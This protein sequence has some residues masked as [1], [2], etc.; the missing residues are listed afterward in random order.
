MNV[1][2]NLATGEREDIYQ[3]MQRGMDL[4]IQLTG[5]KQKIP[6]GCSKWFDTPL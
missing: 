1:Y 2:Q 5:L 3:N 4:W 6:H